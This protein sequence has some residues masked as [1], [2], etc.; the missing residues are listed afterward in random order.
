MRRLRPP[1]WLHG[2]TPLAAMSDWHI[3]KGPTML[4]NVT[5]AV[6]IEIWA[7]GSW[8]ASLTDGG[9]SLQPG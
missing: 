8:A 3:Q 7:P 5:G 2:H 9:E 6:I 1:L 4:V